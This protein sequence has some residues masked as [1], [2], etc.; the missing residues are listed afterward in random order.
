MRVGNNPNRGKG[1]E[2]LQPVILSVVT[3]LPNQEGYHEKRL[4]VIKT[5]LT[6]MRAGAGVGTI[7]VWDNGSCDALRDWLR[8]EYKPDLLMLSANIGKT[9]ARTSIIR[10]C[11]PS[12]FV[13]YSDDDMYFYPGW[14]NQQMDL[15]INFPNVAAVSGYPVRTSFRWGTMNTIAWAGT[16]AKLEIGRFIPREYEDDFCRSIGRDIDYHVE[17]TKDDKDYRATYKGRQAYCTA[18]HCQFIG[19]QYAL[20]KACKYDGE[21]MGD[22]KPFD[23]ALDNLGLRLCTTQR[24]TRH[25]GNVMEENYA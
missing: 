6:T 20:A 3:H 1:A 23:V 4:D 14:L 12:S 8:D 15:L 18:H 19:Y 11:P 5:C 25:M 16:N 7:L 2:K 17:Y 9:A 24:L 22:E 13:G 21:A 10:M